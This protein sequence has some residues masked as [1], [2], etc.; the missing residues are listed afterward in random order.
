MRLLC[1]ILGKKP[2][3][4]GYFRNGVAAFIVRRS[5]RVVLEGIEG[6]YGVIQIIF[7]EHILIRKALFNNLKVI[8]KTIQPLSQSSIELAVILKLAVVIVD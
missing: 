4:C 8:G 2:D 5:S 7:A 1:F 6:L 3:N